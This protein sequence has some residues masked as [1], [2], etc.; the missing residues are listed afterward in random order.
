MASASI[1]SVDGRHIALTIA[2]DPR[3]V[4]AVIAPTACLGHGSYRVLWRV[5]SEDGHP[6]DGS[7]AFTV[8]SEV[9]LDT[10]MAGMVTSAHDSVMAAE[11]EGM[12]HHESANWGTSVLGA[13]VAL[14]VLRGLALG[15]LLS[16]T[17]L[18]FFRSGAGIGDANRAMT[19]ARWLAL[20]SPL[21]LIVHAAVWVMNTHAQHMLN[22]ESLDVA[23]STGMGRRELLRIGFALI[24]LWAF[25]L[26]RL[27]RVT[28]VASVAA[29]LVSSAIGH[30]AAIVPEWAIPGKALHLLASAA[31]IGGVLW[32]LLLDRTDVA[33]F[34]HETARVS[35]A[36]MLCV[37]VVAI[38]G[39]VEIRLFLTM[40]A[41]LIHAPYGLLVLAKVA[42]TL[43]LIGFGAHHRTRGMQKAGDAMWSPERFATTLRGEIVIMALVVLIGG[44]LSYVPPPQ[45]IPTMTPPTTEP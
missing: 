30:T 39:L 37:I 43:A 16:F 7:Y 9:P 38:S 41:D 44:L 33:R 14:A 28:L 32:L 2:G 27:T 5:V 29:L 3:D 6:V 18:L 19:V 45:S 35:R 4:R 36:A 42:G 34:A 23:V 25:L 31:W 17:G 40:P 8:G 26:A 1:V 13:P 15:A 24:A 11:G 10:T 12:M 22:A 21:L 20:A